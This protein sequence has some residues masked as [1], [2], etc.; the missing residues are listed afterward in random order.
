[1]PI[2]VN[3]DYSQAIGSAGLPVPSGADILC[4]DIDFIDKRRLGRTPLRSIAPEYPLDRTRSTFLSD[5]DSNAQQTE[6]VI[7]L[8]KHLQTRLLHSEN[9]NIIS[10]DDEKGITH[11]KD[12]ISSTATPVTSGGE[13]NTEFLGTSC[14]SVAYPDRFCVKTVIV[15]G[16]YAIDSPVVL[17]LDTA[18][19]SS[20]SSSKTSM[21]SR[22]IP[23]TY[24]S[25]IATLDDYV[26]VGDCG[27]NIIVMKRRPILLTQREG[28]VDIAREEEVEGLD[29]FSSP[30]LGGARNVVMPPRTKDPYE[31]YVK[32]KIYDSMIDPLSSLE[33]TPEVTALA[34]LP[35]IGP[36]AY[37]LTSNERIPKLFKVFQVQESAPRFRAVD[38]L[39]SNPIAPLMSVSSNPTV[40][41]KP[42]SHYAPVHEY[43][44][45]SLHPLPD[46]EQFI[47]ADELTMHLWCIEHPDMSIETFDMRP[48]CEDMPHE[49]IRRVRHFPHEPFLLFVATSAGVVRVLD[50]RQSLRWCNRASQLFVNPPRHVDDS[51]KYITNSISDCSLSPCGRYIA[52]RDFM[53]V[54]LWDVR[55]ASS[56]NTAASISRRFS[57]A[58]RTDDD[59]GCS[60]NFKIVRNWE[61]YPGLHRNLEIMYQSDFFLQKLDIQFMNPTQVG[62]GGLCRTIFTV[63]INRTTPDPDEAELGLS[64]SSSGLK[65]LQLPAEEALTDLPK[66]IIPTNAFVNFSFFSG[67]YKG[68]ETITPCDRISTAHLDLESQVTCLSRPMISPGRVYGMLACCRGQIIHLSYS[69]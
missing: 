60:D 61:L 47:T 68:G 26:A 51:Y 21:E 3:A 27:G 55:A 59:N 32:K 28:L 37:L 33:V 4:T 5:N 20:L 65:A 30:K 19:S 41:I 42:V 12:P 29:T 7:T 10:G 15:E 16:A 52:G 14:S 66:A 6:G 69:S 67:E 49:T 39:D 24:I 18:S 2:G 45:H 25:S 38:R 48:S 11:R 62:T 56:A 8:V 13:S 57:S 9:M 63:D 17:P 35:Q 46:S 53:S 1:M 31:F 44:I 23:K 22:R 36:A 43:T 64:V 54:C 34:F 58:F 50:I 40:I